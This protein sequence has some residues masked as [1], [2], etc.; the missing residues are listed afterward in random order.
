[1]KNKLFLRHCVPKNGATPVPQ[2]AL[3]LVTIA[4][5]DHSLIDSVLTPKIE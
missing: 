3:P 2:M 1:M 4:L 5:L